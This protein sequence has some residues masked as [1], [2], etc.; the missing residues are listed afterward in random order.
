MIDF[1]ESLEMVKIKCVFGFE[2]IGLITTFSIENGHKVH[3]KN[4]DSE[5]SS[6][7]KN[8]RKENHLTSCTFMDK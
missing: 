7:N 2:K 8:D 4:E 1:H 6:K 5:E 3:S